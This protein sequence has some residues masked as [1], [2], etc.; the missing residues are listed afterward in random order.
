MYK[1][2]IKISLDKKF[3]KLQK[4]DKDTLRLINRKVKDILDDPYR[5]KPL[6]K[7]LQNIKKSSCWGIL[8][9]NLPDQ[10]KRKNSYA[11]RF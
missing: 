11:F 3:K 4:K 8:R 9:V 2:A 5:F 6:R 1:L 10:S 7:P